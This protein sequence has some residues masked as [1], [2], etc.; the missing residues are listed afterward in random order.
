[1]GSKMNLQFRVPSDQTPAAAIR[2]PLGGSVAS[3][4]EPTIVGTLGSDA[5]AP[6]HLNRP[7]QFKV[8][9]DLI[10]PPPLVRTYLRWVSTMS[11]DK[12]L[13]L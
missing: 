7:K 10:P 2:L 9:S 11:G 5:A 13:A 12:F 1:M 4:A 3:A 6:R 8:P